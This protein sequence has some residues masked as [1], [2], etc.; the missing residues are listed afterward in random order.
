ML[1][2]MRTLVRTGNY[3]IVHV[4]TPVAGFVTRLALDPLRHDQKLQV[5]Y[6]AHG[7]HSHPRGGNL[8]NKLFEAIER[9]AAH[10]TDFLVV[11]NREDL[12]TA[13]SKGIIEADR[14]RYMPGIGVDRSHYS[15]ASVSCSELNR[16]HAELGIS[17]SD[18]ILLMLAEFT[19]NKRHADAIRAFSRIDHP[20]AHL[21]LAGTGPLFEAMNKLVARLGIAD[22]VHFLGLR[23]D[24]PVLIKASRALL[25]PSGREGLPRCVLESL[26]MGVPVIGTRIRGTSEL[27]EE[28]AGL[29]VEVGDVEQLARAMQLMI[30]D[31]SLAT[32][33]GQAGRRRSETYDQ[34]HVLRLHETLYEEALEL[35]R[36]EACKSAGSGAI[37]S[38]YSA[39]ESG[40]RHLP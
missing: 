33:M 28:G 3:D 1:S 7:L 13:R 17:N 34:A 24:V 8:Q 21:L 16:L 38:A 14:L 6:T 37:P 11:I 30:D 4:H 15:A 40:R 36:S 19:A 39:I 23:K 5:I 9:H 31:P 35:R 20:R 22:R 25:L 18:P 2:R 10:R 29:L 26:S 27:V 12:G 32:T